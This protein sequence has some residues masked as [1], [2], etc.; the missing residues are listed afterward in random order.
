[1]TIFG[2]RL[3]FLIAKFAFFFQ[4]YKSVFFVTF[5]ANRRNF[6]IFRLLSHSD[7]NR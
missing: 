5:Y 1:M 6:L 4:S 7:D 3:L 2:L